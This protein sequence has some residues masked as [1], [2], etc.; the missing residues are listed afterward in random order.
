MPHLRLLTLAGAAL[1][2]ALAVLYVMIGRPVHAPGRPAALAQLEEV[3]PARLPAVNF[4]DAQ[5]RPHSLADFKGRYVLLNLWATWC[6]PCVR[7]LPALAKLEAAMPPG[8]PTVVAVN[9]WHSDSARTLAFLKAHD[10]SGLAAYFDPHSKLMTVFGEVG[11][12]YSVLVDPE[13]R[14]VARALGPAGWDD[15]AAIAY[16]KSLV[17]ASS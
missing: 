16:F 6:A 2:A 4:E 12:P 11:L 5:G 17:H 7:E 10:A 14:E 13:G 9:V 3:K 1:V 15:P 8:G